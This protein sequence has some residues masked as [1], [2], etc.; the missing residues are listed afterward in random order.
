NSGQ[1]V[2]GAL[3]IIQCTCLQGERDV[4]TN[5]DGLYTFRNL[6]Q[7][8]YTV[9]VLYQDANVSKTMDVLPGTKMRAN[10]DIDPKYKFVVDI[11]VQTRTRNDAAQ[12]TKI[13]PDDVRAVPLGGTSRD[14]TAVV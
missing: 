14:F 10:F 7:G 9:Q 11:D 8:K 6:P 12:V 5:A 13:K 3:V 1:K 2:S 4:M